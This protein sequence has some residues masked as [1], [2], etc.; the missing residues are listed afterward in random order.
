MRRGRLLIAVLVFLVSTLIWLG[1]GLAQSQNAAKKLNPFTGNEEAIKEGRGLYIQ[2]GCSGCHGAGGG[3]G[4]GPALSDD[5]WKFGS[6]DETLYKLI[7]GQ[8]AESTMPKVWAGLDEDQVW[9]MLAYVR[10]LYKGDP[11]RMNW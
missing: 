1:L 7:K 5:E 10:S 2:Y 3:G 4:M 9:K 8:I 6:D 11:G